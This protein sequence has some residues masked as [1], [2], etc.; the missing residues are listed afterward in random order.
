MKHFTIGILL[1]AA[2]H[3]HAQTPNALDA[4]LIQCWS[5]HGKD[6]PPKDPTIPVI[7]GQQAAYLEKQLRDFRAGTRDSQIMSSMAE[8]VPRNDI[9]K[10][11]GIIA[12]MPWP[13]AAGAAPAPAPGSVT[14][15]GACHG[16]ELMGG[17]SPEGAAPRLAGQSAEYLAD[18]M[19]NFALGARAKA[20]TM[21]AMMKSLKADERGKI[22]KYLAGL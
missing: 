13:K 14:A 12:A 17:Q 1:L 19:N 11:A 7:Q 18:E 16:A 15:C 4:A 9:A 6:A 20:V 22:A 8:A 5:C 21:T 3:A 2:S 10:A